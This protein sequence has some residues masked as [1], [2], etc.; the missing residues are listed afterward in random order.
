MLMLQAEKA[1]Q[2]PVRPHLISYC[3]TMDLVAVVTREEQLDVYR[4]NGQRAFGL[5]QKSVGSSIDAIRWK[6]NGTN[7]FGPS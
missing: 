2:Q 3:P 1:L 4:L 5:K 6:F 7:L